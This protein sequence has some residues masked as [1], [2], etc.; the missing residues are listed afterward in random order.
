MLESIVKIPLNNFGVHWLQFFILCLLLLLIVKQTLLRTILRSCG[1]GV[2]SVMQRI[3]RKKKSNIRFSPLPCPTYFQ[4]VPYEEIKM[5]MTRKKEAIKWHIKHIC[6][7]AFTISNNFWP[8]ENYCRALF[9]M[10]TV[11][12]PDSIGNAIRTSLQT[13]KIINIKHWGEGLK[14]TRSIIMFSITF[15]Y[16]VSLCFH[17]WALFNK[18]N[19][20]LRSNKSAFEVCD[21]QWWR[22]PWKIRLALFITAISSFLIGEI[23]RDCSRVLTT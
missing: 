13:S 11:N 12:W 17:L 20:A 2:A 22:F 6:L 4:T 15:K 16:A 9:F 5:H 19:E 10:K 18:A 3:Q 7:S 1:E 14:V 23:T 8:K 21:G